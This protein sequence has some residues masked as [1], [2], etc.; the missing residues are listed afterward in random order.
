MSNIKIL[1]GTVASVKDEEKINRIQVSIPGFTDEIEI[2]DLPW[3]FPFMGVDYLPLVNETVCVLIFNDNI[4]QGFYSNK[5]ISLKSNGLEGT[6]YENY[7]EIYKRLE[8][9]LS[10]KE[11]FG[12]Q[13]KNKESNI[14]IDEEVINI[15]GKKKI[16]HNSGS[17]PMLLGETTFKI[18]TRLVDAILVETHQTPNGPSSPPINK[19]TYQKIKSDLEQIKSE[20][21]FLD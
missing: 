16:N 13:L 10:Y 14:Q 11:S 1:F 6:E 21:S 3:Y 12:I 19:A 9:E 18:L 4:T 8:V 17:E 15:I 2:K 5:N 7:L 20:L